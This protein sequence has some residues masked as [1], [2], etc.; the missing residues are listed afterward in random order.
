[1]LDSD[2]AKADLDPENRFSWSPQLSLT[3]VGIVDDE[4]YMHWC[5]DSEAV[6]AVRDISGIVFEEYDKG[7]AQFALA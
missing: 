1:M 7:R 6:K 4:A 3:D 5:K 2:A